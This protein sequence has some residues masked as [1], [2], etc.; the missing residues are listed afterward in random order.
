MYSFDECTKHDCSKIVTWNNVDSI[1]LDRVYQT[2][3]ILTEITVLS[4]SSKPGIDTLFSMQIFWL[5]QCDGE[6]SDV[7]TPNLKWKADEH[8]RL[9][10]LDEKS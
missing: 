10:F 1:G 3:T 5:I 8:R 4:Q 2:A 6:Q 9:F 7:T